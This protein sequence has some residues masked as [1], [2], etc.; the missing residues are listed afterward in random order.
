[1][2]RKHLPEVPT[3]SLRDHGTPE[4]I[5]RIW[6]RL[7][8]DLST[9]PSRPRAVLWWA[10]AA[11]LIVFGSGVVV[12]A[13]WGR[14]D[15]LPPATVQ[16]EPRGPSEEPA[17]GFE[18]PEPVAPA[19][20]QK[21]DQEKQRRVPLS[22]IETP[23]VA[24][25]PEIVEPMTPLTSAVSVPATPEWTVLAE[26]GLFKE[27]RAAIERSGGFD[28]AI[29]SASAEQLMTL[30][31]LA[32]DAGQSQRAIAALRRVVEHFA[33][34][35]NAP[36]AAYTLG[37]LLERSGDKAGASRAFEAYRRLSPKGDFAED[38]LARQVEV[39]IEQGNVELARQL[40]DQY[41][42]DFPKG[43]RLSEIRAQIAKLTGEPA[44]PKASPSS[45]PRTEDE[46]PSEEPEEPAPP[47]GK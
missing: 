28:A 8:N 38:A 3:E 46:S 44:Q 43:R 4:R 30:A 41:A 10:P 9:N 12:G 5:D 37:T 26:K 6:R 42:K 13:R 34:D 2:K 39:A 16:A 24:P 14:S 40:A 36:L 7:E 27:A 25:L 22:P 18:Q 32:R 17:S 35:P 47:A 21:R 33:T 23:E 45:A 20:Q 11:V 15:A 31:D 1:M 29:A 19:P